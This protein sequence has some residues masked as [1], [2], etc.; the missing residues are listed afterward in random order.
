MKVGFLGLG[1][2]GSAMATNLIKAGHEVTVYNRS[3]DKAEALAGEGAKVAAT[4]AD[5]CG[6]EAVFTMLAHDD[7]LSAVVHGDGGVLASLGK[8]AVHISA[9]TI[10]VAMSERLTREHAAAGQHFVAAPV[11]GRPEAAAAAKLFVAAAGAP[12][13]I[14]SVTPL[15]NAIGQRTFILG[16]EPKAANLVKL[17]GNFLIASVI[18]SLGEAMALVEK[19][20]IDR[21]A[22][23]DLLTST[24]FNAPVYKTYGGLIADRKF[25]PAGFTAPLGQ[26]DIRLALAA[27]EALNVPLPL[28]SLLRDRFLNLLAHGG[29]ELDW[30]AIGALAAKDAGLVG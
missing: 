7:A 3:R 2:M 29:E 25:Q 30:S 18:E 16:E 11:F 10:S 12:D 24:L 20:G 22:Y 23:L 9:S 13:A 15:F 6:G 21:H 8:G 26:K 28:A 5:A 14:Q 19:G 4:V 17:S 1:Q 27:G